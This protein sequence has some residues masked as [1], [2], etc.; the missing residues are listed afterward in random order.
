MLYFCLQIILMK[1]IFLISSIILFAFCN[2][3]ES[4]KLESQNNKELS[5]EETLQNTIK[6]Y[7]DSLKLITDLSAYYLDVQNYDAALAQINNAIAKDSNNAQL[8]DYQSIIYIAKGDTAK[9]INSLE[10]AINIFPNPQYIIGLGALYAQSKNP[11]ALAMADALLAANKA[12]AEKEAY[13]IKGIYYSYINEK[14]KAIS[15]FDK[16][17]SIQY[18]FMDAY[19]EKGIALYDLKKYAE[20]A[21]VLEKAV[22]LQNNYDKGYYYLGRCFEK[23]NKKEDAVEAYQMALR[24][25]PNYVEAKDALGRLQ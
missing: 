15:F 17:I 23:L 9:A 18:S 10:A 2:N 14:E 20:A 7:P 24:Y 1:Y 8:R 6:K 11:M 16:C 25:D 12:G 22:T 21:T 5:Q 4:E 13:F 3:N 19:L